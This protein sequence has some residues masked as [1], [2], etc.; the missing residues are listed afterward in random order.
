MMKNRLLSLFVITVLVLGM[1]LY[2]ANQRAPS[3][4]GEF[5]PEPLIPGLM[6][7][8]NKV[9]GIK[10]VKSGNETIVEL[11]REGERWTVASQ[12]GYP[13][14]VSKV[15]SYLLK[16]AESKLRE[17][18]TTKAENYA[19]L[20]VQ[21]MDV[22]DAVG[23]RLE[24]SG[25]GAEPVSLI[26]GMNA[27]GSPA[28]FVRKAGAEQAFL[29]SGDLMPDR[30]KANWTLRQILDLPS[31]RVREVEITDPEGKVLKVSK[32]D[33]GAF[34]YTVHDV[35]KGKS[36]SSESAGNMLG[37]VLATLNF[38]DVLPKDQAQPDPA[39]LFKARYQSYEGLQI[40]VEQ[41]DI[42]GKSYASFKASL[43][44][45]QLARHLLVERA[46]AELE[47]KTKEAEAA[48]K[49]EAAKAAGEA[50]A[51]GA[52]GEA[53]K[54]DTAKAEG[55]TPPAPA[56]DAEKFEAETRA[57]VEQEIAE[58]NARTEAWVYVLPGWKAD[59]IKKRMDDMLAK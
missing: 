58:I 28:T 52:D 2:F 46:K 42:D 40:A 19:R 43:D 41:W 59:N 21:D 10:L 22:A 23:A 47:A 34:N 39:T 55:E 27:G 5:K 14:D 33:P 11:R 50:A 44:E 38:D 18:K 37:G 51:A 6:E 9:D 25:L 29:A 35:P 31:A 26:I 56:F 53:A 24:L 36:L 15:R 57:K 1:G 54:A 16:L 13:A 20:G 4:E 17:P 48:A 8:I 7:N 30:E 12:H 3:S 32:D 45:A 49:A